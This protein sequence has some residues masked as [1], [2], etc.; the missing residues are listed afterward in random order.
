MGDVRIPRLGVRAIVS[1]DDRQRISNLATTKL[2]PGFTYR[3]SGRS[4]HHSILEIVE[5]VPACSVGRYVQG[6]VSGE[7]M[8]GSNLPVLFSP[9]REL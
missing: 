7:M 5:Y 8:R 3:S 4:Q 1:A 2:L 6:P 9:E